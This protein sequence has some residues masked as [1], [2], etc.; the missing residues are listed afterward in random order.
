MRDVYL[1]NE[2][3]SSVSE[4]EQAGRTEIANHSAADGQDEERQEAENDGET[5]RKSNRVF[6][7]R[8]D[9]PHRPYLSLSDK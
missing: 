4:R 6:A 3:L 9:V 8:E 7:R 1:D 2:N 5:C